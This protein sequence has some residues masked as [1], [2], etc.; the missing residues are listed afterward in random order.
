MWDE[1]APSDST[2]IRI[3]YYCML[4]E[5]FFELSPIAPTRCPRCFCDARYII[6]PIPAKE[7]DLDKLVARQRRKYGDKMRR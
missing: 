4:C 1:L 6:G 3:R 2:P 7:Y 5:D